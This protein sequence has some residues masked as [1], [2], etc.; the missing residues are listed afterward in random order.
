MRERLPARRQALGFDVNHPVP[1]SAVVYRVT[2]GHDD[3]GSVREIFI[4][5]NKLTTS[6]HI[7]GLEIATLASIALQHGASVAE[8]AA[9]MPRENDGS[10]QGA[11][12]A[13]L[14][15]VLRVSG[16]TP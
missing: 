9:A 15:E 3:A 8:I 12:G 5:C 6:M 11:A 14:D 16:D 13:V 10:P 1:G 4:G 2:L 7:A